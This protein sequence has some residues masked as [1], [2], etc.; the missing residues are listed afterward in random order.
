MTDTTWTLERL[1]YI[2][3]P[4]KLEHEDT[5]GTLL[6]NGIIL[7]GVLE[8]Y[9]RIVSRLGFTIHLKFKDENKILKYMNH[10]KPKKHEYPKNIN[11][12]LTILHSNGMHESFKLKISLEPPN[13]PAYNS[14]DHVK[15]SIQFESNSLG[16]KVDS[17]D[18]PY[19]I[20]KVDD[21]FYLSFYK[22]YDQDQYESGIE[23]MSSS[24][25]DDVDSY[26]RGYSDY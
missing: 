15:G 13:R 10:V 21:E 2:R 17:D 19:G 25:D 5:F 23:V 8:D 6:P 24:S 7:E 14:F 26:D 20:P 22:Q 3:I 4:F 11:S 18:I 16:F 1:F 9:E 12:V